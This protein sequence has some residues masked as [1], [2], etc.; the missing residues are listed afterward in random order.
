MS[1][2]GWKKAGALALMMGAVAAQAQNAPQPAPAQG[3]EQQEQAPPPKGKVLFQ[4]HG[5]SP[6][7]DADRKPLAA[8][9]QGD[10]VSDRERAALTFTAYDL[11]AHVQPA[12]AR[13]DVR[14]RVTVRNDGAEPL[15]RLALQL[16]SALDWQSAAVA[17]PHKA[18]TFTQAAIET[19]TDHTGLVHEAVIALPK[20]LAPGASVVLDVFYGGKVEA[21][22]E[23]LRRIGASAAQADAADWDAV[24]G[25]GVNLRG[26]GN[27]LWYPVASPALFLGDANKL[28]EGVGKAKLRERAAT[29][30][31][32]LLVEYAGEPPVAAYFCGRRREFSAVSDN[33]DAP[34]A[35]GYGV[36]VAEFPAEPLGFRG[37]SLFVVPEKEQRLGGTGD[38]SSS[39]SSSSVGASAEGAPLAVVSEQDKVLPRLEGAAAEATPLLEDWLGARPLTALTILDHKGQPFQDGP[40]LVAPVESLASSSAAGA[41][42]YSLTHAWVDTGQPWI[43]EGL[44]Q[45]LALE[46]TER[47]QGRDAAVAEMQTMLQPLAVGEPGYTS[48]AEVAAGGPGQPVIAAYDEMFYRRKAAAVWW[49]LRDLAGE[50][51]LKQAL[52]AWRVQPRSAED[53]RAQAVGFEKLLEKISG[54]DLGWFFNDWVLRDVG[55]PDLTLADV[56]PRALPAGKGHDSGWLVAVTVRN[57]GAAATEVPLVVRAGTFSV[58]RR[59]RVAGF[60]SATERVLVEAAPTEVVLNDGTVPEVR[61]S[62]HSRTI[63]VQ[64]Q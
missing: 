28:F 22:S 15:S 10:D 20:P 41:M 17:N 2:V 44:A 48:A 18:L 8:T 58:T 49:M 52:T 11:E 59:M 19:D 56:T 37:M 38:V 47:A 40:L 43:D 54:Q 51:A 1:L 4:S 7:P 64:A 35:S 32:R 42:T 55:L 39:S 24:S 31:L 61:T 33:A 53:A 60:S 14:A 23:R 21:S 12:G 29:V 63:K 62:V 34:T 36:A 6:E 46:Q 27:V 26:F 13:L 50:A 25:A 9:A 3:S 5:E 45:F 16:S 30:K 57:D